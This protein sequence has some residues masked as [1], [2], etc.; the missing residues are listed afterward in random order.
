MNVKLLVST[1]A[2]LSAA[3]G[4]VAGYIYAK[5]TLVFGIREAALAEAQNE[6]EY[7]KDYYDKRY[8]KVHKAGEFA[9]PEQMAVQYD[10]R[11]PGENIKPDA[12]GELPGKPLTDEEL[13]QQGATDAQLEKMLTKMRSWTT[14]ENDP[15]PPVEAVVANAVQTRNIFQP[16]SGIVADPQS[17]DNYRTAAAQYAVG[18]HRSE[19]QMGSNNIVL[20]DFNAYAEND[21]EHDQFEWDCYQEPD[22]NVV[23]CDSE[24]QVVD[25]NRVDDYLGGTHY[26]QFGSNPD[27]PNTVRIRNYRIKTDFEINLRAGSYAEVAGFTN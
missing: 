6:V 16:D 21:V 7:W 27:E 17:I 15:R 10:K 4:T 22:G 12:M 1:M 11:V 20:I 5:K 24:D 8:Q 3:A 26:L 18:A 2:L 25:N 23:I 19:G 14:D 13:A 9:D